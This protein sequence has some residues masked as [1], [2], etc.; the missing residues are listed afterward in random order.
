MKE[1]KS[2]GYIVPHTHWDREWRY[3]IWKTRHL[4]V[5]LM[6]EILELLDTDPSYRC[7]LMDGQ[8]VPIE[9]YLL[10]R[11]EAEDKIKSYVK[12]GRII[13]GPWFTLPDTWP[14]D[15]ECLVRNL[16][17]GIRYSNSLGSCLKIGYTSFGWGQI[18]QF[19]Q[20]HA[21]FG[22]DFIVTAKRITTEHAPNAEF[23]W[24]S[25]DGTRVLTSRLGPGGRHSFFMNACI[26][27]SYGANYFGPDY[28]F[29]PQVAGVVFHRADEKCS[30]RDHFKVTNPKDY[31]GEALKDGIQRAWNETNDTLA[32]EDRL[33]L[34]GCD[35][36][37]AV[38]ALGRII[39]EANNM[40][41]DKEFEHA[42]LN[43]YVNALKESIDSSKLR[44]I[45][46]ELRDGPPSAGTLNA[47]ATRAPIK[48]LNKKAQNMLIHTAEPLSALADTNLQAKYPRS[49]LA[50]A[51]D[52]MM[53]SHPHDSINGVTQDKTVNDVMYRL[54]QAIELADVVSE[55]AIGE[56]LKSIDFSAY[57][58]EDQF[59]VVI[60]PSWKTRSNVMKISVD[61]PR[62]ENFWD[63]SVVDA[64]GNPVEIQSISR[65]SRDAVVHDRNSRPWPYYID[66]HELFINADNVPAGGY[67]TYKVVPGVRFGRN[68]IFGQACCT[69]KGQD[70]MCC[71]NILENEHLRVKINSNGTFDL[72][73]K[74][75]GKVF[76]DMN[77]FEDAGDS[78]NYWIYHP[79]YHNRIYST[80][81][82]QARTWIEENGPLCATVGIEI[83]MQLP[84]KCLV[85]KNYTGIDGESRR[86][87][88]EKELKIVTYLTLKRGSERVDIRT[89]IDNTVEDHRMRALFPTGIQA[90]NACSAGHFTVDKRPVVPV[91]DK[92]GEYT[93]GMEILP[94]QYFVDLSDGK[95]GL[96]VVNDCLGEYE[97]M[98]DAER[99]L[100]I[101]LFRSVRASICTDYHV[102][103]EY[104]AQKGSQLQG[105]LEFNYAVYPHMGD[106]EQGNVYDEAIDFNVPMLPVQTMWHNL[107]TL[108]LDN[109]FY[110]LKSDKLVVSCFKKA[111]DRDSFIVR[112]F[113]PSSDA[114]QGTL[115]FAKEVKCAYIT[116]MN[117]ERETEIGVSNGHDVKVEAQTNKIITIEIEFE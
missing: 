114:A 86:V 34:C 37:S 21:G 93:P 12:A 103:S 81:N 17:K 55:N 24:E 117:E 74:A 67:S 107:G 23:L 96:S 91:K 45:K 66:R 3:P 38:P 102:V 80:R 7:F 50:L 109:S 20:I 94:Q 89:V 84:E 25:P 97:A 6:D 1:N 19:P 54:N 69:S 65:I 85:P 27:A 29:G 4:L 43:D 68:T 8:S 99:T 95:S 63:F 62:D 32:Q 88:N 9:D 10:I 16:L 113:N 83:K 42:T 11:P 64:D 39:S 61:I 71:H 28:K 18:A 46:G 58:P 56:I 49:Y 53:K 31:H 22:I 36:T 92:N 5:E 106:W 15:A 2:K 77:Y 30:E 79:P 60:N 35:F 87:D 110:E 14:L 115:H 13:V 48:Q 57:K 98:D 59:I 101:T 100:A 40:F 44:V 104:P 75:T 78:G 111:E 112:M 105:K 41:D 52:Y 90:K 108:P 116:N 47:A 33:F 73:Q 51:W 72:T 70:I 82:A 76:N 26:S